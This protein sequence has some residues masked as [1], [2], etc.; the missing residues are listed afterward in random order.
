[1]GTLA[2]M[3]DKFGRY[4]EVPESLVTS[5]NPN[6]HAKYIHTETPLQQQ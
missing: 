2:M 3:E 1:M 4:L 5:S 6:I